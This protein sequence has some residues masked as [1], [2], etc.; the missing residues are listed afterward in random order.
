MGTYVCTISNSVIMPTGLRPTLTYRRAGWWRGPWGHET[1][2]CTARGPSERL[3][4]G[5]LR[6][7]DRRLTRQ[8]RRQARQF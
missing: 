8:L 4:C 2:E 7:Q 3:G 6:L 5:R 1:A